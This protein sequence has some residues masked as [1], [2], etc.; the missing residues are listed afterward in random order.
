MLLAASIGK[1]V[2]GPALIVSAF[3]QKVEL[4][5]PFATNGAE[6][7]VPLAS[8]VAGGRGKIYGIVH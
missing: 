5:D 6:E 2:T 1:A 3:R 4:T 7:P 8:V